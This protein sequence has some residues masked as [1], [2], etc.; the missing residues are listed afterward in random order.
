MKAIKKMR[1]IR[2]PKLWEALVP[3]FA[4]MIIIIVGILKYELEPHI[5]IVLASIIAAIMAYR[6]GHS[7]SSIL[8]GML[9]SIHR[10]LEALIIVMIVGMLIGTWVSAGTVPAMVYYG[11]GIISPKWFLPTGAILCAIVSLSTGS[12]WTSSGTVGIALMSIAVGLGINPALAA[13]MVISGAYFGDKLSP[14]SDSTNVAAATAGAPLYEHVGSMMRTTIPS[15]AIAL[16][17]YSIIGITVGGGD[18]DPERVELIRMTILDNFNINLWLLIPPLFV[19]FAAI[20]KVPSIPSLL[21]AAGLGG[22]FGIIFQGRNIGEVL[23]NFHYGFEAD[24]GVSVVDRLLNR[25]GV[26]SMM[27]TISLIIFAL[28][29]GGILE[30]GGFTNVIL[31]R[32]VNR[33]K[34]VGGLVTLTV[35]TGILSNF[36]LT[37]QY[38]SIIVPGRMYVG[39]FDKL[40]LDRKFLSRTLEDGGTMWSPLCPWN[41]CGAYQAATLGVATFSY[42]PFAFMNLINPIVAIVFAY[43]GIS[44]FYKKEQ[45]PEVVNS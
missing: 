22:L 32:L 21:S 7:W 30:R 3:I 1:E 28:A 23:M 15:F 33:V 9:E 13:G 10:A 24:T 8:G 20:K 45:N 34:T 27:W 5:P 16:V 17:I 18:Y 36:I 38:L 19:I 2:T 42:L 43:L 40:N 29:F 39:A 35:T 44:V 26:D 31:S 14:L 25:G 37:D 41:G 6:V 12:S 11:L 4:M